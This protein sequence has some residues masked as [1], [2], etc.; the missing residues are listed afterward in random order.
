MIQ[1]QETQVIEPLIQ[2]IA[3]AGFA[4]WLISSVVGLVIKIKNNGNGKEQCGGEKCLDKADVRDAIKN[5]SQ[6]AEVSIDMKDHIG[7]VALI[8]NTQ[9]MTLKLLL[10]ETE[11]QTTVL[12]TIARNGKK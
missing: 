8:H 1:G 5:V 3:G 10:K 6:M 12:E 4:G 9:D 11:K 2:W 7:K